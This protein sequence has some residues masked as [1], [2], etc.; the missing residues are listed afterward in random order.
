[1]HLVEADL[2]NPVRLKVIKKDIP[3]AHSLCY[4]KGTG[5]VLIC[6]HED[7]VLKVVDIEYRLTLKVS[8]LKDRASLVTEL[9]RPRE[10]C[11]GTVKDLKRRFEECLQVE[12]CIYQSQGKSVDIVHLDQDIKPSTI[13]V[14]K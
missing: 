7:Q 4:L 10:S 6:C 9:E 11:D 8:R 3:M 5:T 14:L 1:M 2:H 13:C 12:Q